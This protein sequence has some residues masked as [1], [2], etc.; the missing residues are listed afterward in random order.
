L[1]AVRSFVVVG[2]KANA[3]GDWL[4]DDVPGTSGRID[5][6]LRCVRAALLTSHGVRH[7]TRVYLVFE[8]A[9]RVMRIDGKTVQFLR[10]DERALAVLARK[11]LASDADAEARS[12]VEVKPG[13]ALARGGLEA[14]L[15]DGPPDVFVL[16]EHATMDIRA[17]PLPRDVTY[18]LGDHLGFSEASRS[19]LA[20]FPTI[21]I[22]PTSLHADDAVAI[23]SNELDRRDL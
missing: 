23:V 13:I 22:G 6:L 2:Q 19:T 17:A 3:V 9:P 5:V 21:T 15:A 8:Q 12:F 16:D 11:V 4:L 18:V 14:A 10:P 20:R 1:E 7:D